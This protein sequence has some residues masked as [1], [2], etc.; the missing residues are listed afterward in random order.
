V[1]KRKHSP[2]RRISNL[3]AAGMIAD[4][5]SGVLVK[6]ISSKFGRPM[7]SVYRILKQHNVSLRSLH[8][9]KAALATDQALQVTNKTAGTPV[10]NSEQVRQ[11]VERFNQELS[12][13]HVQNFVYTKTDK[14]W[15]ANLTKTEQW[16]SADQ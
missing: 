7:G 5:K 15:T 13:L 14:D 11:A 4:Y 12:R 2:R 9:P 16:S 1:K 10:A 6:V 3:Q 8:K